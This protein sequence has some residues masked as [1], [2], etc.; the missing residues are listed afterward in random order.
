MTRGLAPDEVLALPAVVDLTTA[1][2]ALGIGRTKTHELARAGD[3]PVP[4]LRIG[5]AYRIRRAD[6]LRYLGID[7]DRP[8]PP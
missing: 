5:A 3:L 1:G 6:L 8:E 4:V 2:R 7:D